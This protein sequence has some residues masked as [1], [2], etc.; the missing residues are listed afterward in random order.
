MIEGELLMDAGSAY[1]RA[2][3]K[4]VE[5]FN[6]PDFTGS[7]PNGERESSYGNSVTYEPIGRILG[8][9]NGTGENGERQGGC[10]G[11]TGVKSPQ[12]FSTKPFI[13]F[14]SGKKGAKPR[15]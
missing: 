14:T 7:A 15:I 11:K 5:R 6:E 4:Y 12:K 2:I 9:E 10:T 1:G 8:N 13:V 3:S